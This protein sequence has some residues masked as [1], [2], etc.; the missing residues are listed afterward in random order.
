[1]S[2]EKPDWKLPPDATDWECDWE[3]SRRFQLNYWAA[4][5]LKDQLKAVEE[6]GK[7]AAKLAPSDSITPE[8]VTE[9]PPQDSGETKLAPKPLPPADAPAEK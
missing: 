7:L 6:M 3:S 4:Q 8:R 9:M 1:M 5:P 2:E